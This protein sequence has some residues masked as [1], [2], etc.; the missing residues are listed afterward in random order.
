MK[1]PKCK[2]IL[3]KTNDGAYICSSKCGSAYTEKELEDIQDAEQ[4]EEDT[5]ISKETKRSW[6]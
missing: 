4:I 5:Q 3:L 1:C 2:K 6:K